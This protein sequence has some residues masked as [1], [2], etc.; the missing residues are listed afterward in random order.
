MKVEAARSAERRTMWSTV[1]LSAALLL[2]GVAM[3]M[4]YSAGVSRQHSSA[5]NYW[6]SGCPGD[7]G[8]AWSQKPVNLG[9]QARHDC[10]A[11]AIAR[12]SL[13]AGAVTGAGVVMLLVQVASLRR[14]EADS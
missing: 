13:A 10:R 9:R 1:L 4:P 5:L 14:T 6:F 11:G 8:E 12:T 2:G 3:L 7:D